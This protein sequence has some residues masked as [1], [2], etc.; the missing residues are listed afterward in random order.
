M[1]FVVLPTGCSAVADDQG[2][3]TDT[4]NAELVQSLDM[5]QYV[6]PVCGNGG[7]TFQIGSEQFRTVPM[8]VKGGS[9]RFVIVKGTDG[10]GF[11]EW[12]VDATYLRIRLD[13]TW[14]YELPDH[15]W[16]DV[17]CGVNDGSNCQQRWNTN[18]NDP[19]NG[20]SPSSP[21]VFTQY[22]DAKN[23]ALGAPWIPRKLQL[24]MGGSTQ[25][26]TQMVIQ[27]AR[28][29]TCGTCDVNFGTRPGQSVGRTVKATRMAS[30]NGW[31]DVV[32]LRVLSG[33][34][35]GEV[36]DYAR[37]KGWIGFNGKA[38]SAEL[39]TNTMPSSS[40]AGFQPGS[41]CSAVGGSTPTTPTPTPTPTKTTPPPPPPP[42]GVCGCSTTVDN[43][44]LYAR[45]TQGCA[46]TAPGG[47]CDPNGDG[48]FSDADWV[49]GWN[50][51]QQKC[52]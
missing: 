13:T 43:F 32:E 27:G 30:W 9:G 8:G 7:A 26:T 24:P 6:V 16:C 10:A 44:C 48:N 3:E 1:L 20:R 49:R 31:N 46:M 41:I 42:P 17:K 36:Y 28:R 39:T 52:R 4:Q 47:Y 34:G 40:C 11:E 18:P 35:A 15:T 5:A 2:D 14:A 38:A 25:F 51:Y 33:P 21:W 29:D 50:E 37:G 19:R 45:N 22:G 23:P 12:A